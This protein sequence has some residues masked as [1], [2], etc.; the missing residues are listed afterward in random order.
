MRATQV[1]ATLRS[2]RAA[3]RPVM[4]W[5]K[6]G[7]GKS[8]CVAEAARLDKCSLIDWRLALMDAVDLRGIPSLK[9]LGKESVTTWNPPDE[10]PR[11]GEGYLFLDE[12]P[13]AMLA[14]TNAATQLILDRKLGS[15]RMP[16]GW[17]LCA[18]GNREEDMAAVN[19]MPTHVANRFVHI[20]M[21]THLGDWIDWADVHDIDPRVIA[22]IKYRPELL[23]VFEPRS[24][25]KAFAAPRSWKFMSDMMRQVEQVKPAKG[26]DPAESGWSSE[27]RLE[28]AAGIVG[29]QASTEFVGFLRIME[30]LV[31]IESILLAP[32]KAAI[33]KDAAICYA[34]V[35]ALADHTDRGNLK[36]VVKY[37]ERLSKEFGFLYF[38]RIDQ[39]KPDLKKSKEFIAWA[40]KNQH[41]A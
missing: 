9:A 11:S 32:E 39:T 30:K 27:Y 3:G 25:E 24:K 18:A 23:H 10:L 1:I 26:S 19:R 2:A 17:Y 29:K 33:P 36:S 20:E 7:I 31:S 6:P 35:Y 28:L 8:E 14:T 38:R 37:V 13:Q 41:L 34:L 22:F 4:L 12:L 5:G 40:T 21:E 15:Y 16:A